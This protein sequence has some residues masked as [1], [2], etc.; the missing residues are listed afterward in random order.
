MPPI[1][2]PKVKI[3]ITEQRRF[4][5]E[6]GQLFGPGEWSVDPAVSM[7][8][9]AGGRARL[10]GAPAA[11]APAKAPPAPTANNP[12]IPPPQEPEG[13]AEPTPLPEDFPSR[14]TLVAAGLDSV[15]ALKAPEIKETLAGIEGL[16][17]AEITKIG[18]AISKV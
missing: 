15:E 17:P 4:T 9:I 11:K 14:E 16:T 13:E 12:R 6:G 18:L 2:S 3:I 7:R 8:L 10:A 5:D 1:E